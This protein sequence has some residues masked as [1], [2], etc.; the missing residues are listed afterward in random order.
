MKKIISLLIV[1]AVF[2][3][4]MAV[5]AFAE[6]ETTAPL[7]VAGALGNDMVLQRDAEIR[8]W[9]TCTTKGATV[10]VKFKD[11][12]ATATVDEKNNWLAKLPAQS[13][14]ANENTL[15]VTQGSNTVTLTGILVGDVYF[16]GGQS[17]AEKTLTACGTKYYTN[18]MK[19]E[20]IASA[21]DKIRFFQQSRSDVMATTKTKELMNSPQANPLAKK[22]WKRE[23]LNTANS[24]SAIGFFFAHKMYAETN[25]PIGMVMVASSGSP[26]SQLMST[27][28]AVKSNYLKYENNIPVSGMY[29]TLMNPFI[30]MAIK[31]MIFYQG[32]SE[33][34]L[35]VSDYGKYNEYLKIY[36]EDLR[37]KMGQNFPF[38]YVQMS[39]HGLDGITSWPNQAPQRAVQAESYKTIDNS[40]FVVSMDMGYCKGQGDWAHPDRKQ[41]VGERLAALALCRL[42]GIGDEEYVTSPIPE[43][44][45]K[46]TEGFVIHFTHVAG[47]LKKGGSYEKLTGFKLVSI[48]GKLTDVEAEIINENEVLLK[49]DTS[50]LLKGVGYGMEV[51]AFTDPTDAAEE[52]YIANLSNGADLP[53]PTF[54]IFDILSEKPSEKKE[55]AT[56][57]QTTEPTATSDNGAVTS[58]VEP[59]ATA[60][61]T[62]KASKSDTGIIIGV[63]AAGVVVLGG[64]AAFT[65]VTLKKKKKDE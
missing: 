39:S 16:V 57:E 40:G 32:E 24:F 9:G 41:P 11:A 20:M 8:I 43:Y 51:C 31:G 2:C 12:E 23:T 62:A 7:T 14:D 1:L 22:A 56:A 53:A 13:A 10:T 19:K 34:G 63:V 48:D 37:A 47:G 33:M 64:I 46:T 61:A 5:T 55:E 35:A 52:K 65:V 29:N 60:E 6:E 45:Y 18:A 28:A 50:A 36:V 25:V 27:E 30:N 54:Q 44:A 4:A 3:S 42:Y 59:T 49:A 17:N 26:L 21:N 38:Y 58:T 15:T